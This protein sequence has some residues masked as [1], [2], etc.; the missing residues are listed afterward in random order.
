[1]KPER[2][3]KPGSN[4]GAVLVTAFNRPDLLKNLLVFLEPFCLRIYVHVDGPRVA[5]DGDRGAMKETVDMVSSFNL[6]GTHFHKSN[7]GCKRGMECG[8][9]WFFKCE[10]EG[11]ILED[12][13]FPCED[14]IPFA[15]EM[16]EIHREDRSIW[17]ISGH[18]QGLLRPQNVPSY[19]SKYAHIWGWASWASRWELH[20]KD[21]TW[22]SNY[23][24]SD[25]YRRV[26]RH[27]RERKYWNGYMDL[28]MTGAIDTWDL[29]F[30]AS[31]W[32]NRGQNLSSSQ[33]L[34]ENVGFREDATHTKLKPSIYVPPLGNFTGNGRRQP[35]TS[36]VGDLVEFLE[37]AKVQPW[38]RI[39]QKFRRLRAFGLLNDARVT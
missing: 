25:E 9:D 14:F 18:P 3:R 27:E 6:A 23:T 4:T 12:D 31:M 29:Q 33:R 21:L 34:V 24:L 37:I 32:R 22:W 28:V 17:M 35:K 20:Q 38:W 5:S 16:L 7:L 13:V 30:Q 26:H 15:L 2:A 36:R 19:L 11:I 8:L 39:L 1:M 10:P